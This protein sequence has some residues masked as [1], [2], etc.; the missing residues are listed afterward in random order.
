MK[1]PGTDTL[2]IRG[3]TQPY[4]YFIHSLSRTEIWAELSRLQSYSTERSTK[5]LGSFLIPPAS[6]HSY[7]PTLK[8]IGSLFILSSK[9]ETQKLIDQSERW[10]CVGKAFLFRESD[11]NQDQVSSFPLDPMVDGL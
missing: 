5:S 11:T 6:V 1:I 2:E 3:K 4:K 7:T 8:L 10:L 9:S